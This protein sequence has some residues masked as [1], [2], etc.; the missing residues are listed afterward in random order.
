MKLIKFALGLSLLAGA[1]SS[2]AVT[3]ADCNQLSGSA[4]QS[5]EAQLPKPNC[6][7]TYQIDISACVGAPHPYYSYCVA[8]APRKAV[9]VCN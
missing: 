3:A 9:T 1:Y 2:Q 6:T 5:C 8:R 4:R 7:T